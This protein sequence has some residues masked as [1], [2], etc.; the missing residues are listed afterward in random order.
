MGR[1]NEYENCGLCGVEFYVGV[2]AKGLCNDCLGVSHDERVAMIRGTLQPT[3]VAIRE[4]ER[5]HVE[6]W[7]LQIGGQA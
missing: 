5:G 1:D 7:P 6:A 2:G 4:R 3:P